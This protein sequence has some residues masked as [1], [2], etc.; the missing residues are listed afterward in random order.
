MSAT[1][2]TAPSTTTSAAATT[3]SGTDNSMMFWKNDVFKYGILLALIGVLVTSFMCSF[4]LRRRAAMTFRLN[5]VGYQDELR[6][7]A[8]RIPK[9]PPKLIDAHLSK[10]MLRDTLVSSFVN[11]RVPE[12]S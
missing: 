3:T 6:R 11:L 4:T 5:S 1:S 7:K 2:S 9:V 8:K 12:A 10:D